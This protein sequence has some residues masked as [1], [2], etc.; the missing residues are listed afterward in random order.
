MTAGT[1]PHISR[2]FDIKTLLVTKDIPPITIP[3]T[4]LLK[5]A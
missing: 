4:A 3:I 2:S 5:A 1:N